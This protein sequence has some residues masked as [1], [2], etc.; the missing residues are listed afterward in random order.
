MAINT[1]GVQVGEWQTG[2]IAINT[3]NTD[4]IDLGGEFNYIEIW[5][6]TMTASNFS[7]HKLE[8]GIHVT[9]YYRIGPVTNV[10]PCSTG[11]YFDRM[12][13]GIAETIKLMGSVNQ[14]AARLVKVRGVN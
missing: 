13:V 12:Y 14:V 3:K 2:T 5:W 9:T 7:T 8:A 1:E 10:V 6:P 11:G 4:S